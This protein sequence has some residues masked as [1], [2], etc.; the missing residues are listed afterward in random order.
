MG[1]KACGVY[2]D[3]PLT[4]HQLGK[5][6]RKTIGVVELEGKSSIQCGSL[7]KLV[8]LLCEKCDATVESFVERCFLGL[9]RRLHLLTPL[10]QTGKDIPH[11]IGQ[12]ID[13]LVEKRLGKAKGTTVAH[14]APEN[15]PEHIIP[16][17][18]AGKDAITDGKTQRSDVIGNHPEGN[19]DLFLIT[20]RLGTDVRQRGAVTMT[21]EFFKLIKNRAKHIGFIIRDHTIEFSEALRALQDAGNALKT[22]AGIHMPGWQVRKS[23]IGIRIE[24]NKNQVPDFHAQRAVLIDQGAFGVALGGQINMQFRTRAAGSGIPH[25]P[26]IVFFVAVDDVHFRVQS[27]FF[28]KCL[29]E[30]IGLLIEISRV[31]LGWIG[32]IDGGIEALLGKFPDLCQQ[33]PGPLNGFLLEIITKAPVAKHFEKGV[34]VGIHPHIFEVIV[35]ASRSNAFLG[36]GSSP[37][38]IRTWDFSEKNGNK[39]VHP[40][41]GKKQVG[42]IR[43]QTG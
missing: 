23:T 1:F 17:G 35:L 39:L 6:Q 16:V 18:V 19:V 42:S 8:S 32:F 12:D 25:H 20:E 5:V 15:A 3:T 40:C 31:S 21:T 29:P 36:V 37:G 4:C 22:H 27:R 28:E 2:R 30:V 10:P 7:A 43:H 34:M 14:G 24:L 33:F 9:N 38:L 13:Q 11:G 26:E 41:I